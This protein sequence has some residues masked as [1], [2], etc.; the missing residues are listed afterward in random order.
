[1]INEVKTSGTNSSL[2]TDIDSSRRG[3]M[4]SIGLIFFSLSSVVVFAN[5]SRDVFDSSHRRREIFLLSLSQLASTMK[6][7]LSDVQNIRSQQ[8]RTGREREALLLLIAKNAASAFFS[9][10][11]ATAA[12]V[13][14]SP[15][16]VGTKRNKAKSCEHTQRER[17]N[18][19]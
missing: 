2:T 6:M 13:F 7:R 11:A 1:M 4:Q 19:R 12:A 14:F 3:H 10:A 9:F 18:K 17:E 8:A 5:T 15:F 16:D